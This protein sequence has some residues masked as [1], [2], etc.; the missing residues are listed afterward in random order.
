MR[1]KIKITSIIKIKKKIIKHNILMSKNK[2][3]LVLK[4]VENNTWF[5][6]FNQPTSCDKRSPL[7]KL[8]IF[9]KKTWQKRSK[10]NKNIKKSKTTL[11]N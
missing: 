6:Q 2:K 9:L 5:N 7:K 4:K 3:K 1:Y 11:V 8:Y 10:L